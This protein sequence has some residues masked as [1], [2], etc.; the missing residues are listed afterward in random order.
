MK[1][2]VLHLVQAYP[3]LSKRHNYQNRL[4]TIRGGH[5]V[6]EDTVRDA[7]VLFRTAAFIANEWPKGGRSADAGSSYG[8]WKFIR[9]KRICFGLI[10]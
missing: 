7:F 1:I 8:D 9:I 10:P 3:G 4:F 5:H 2:V 6:P